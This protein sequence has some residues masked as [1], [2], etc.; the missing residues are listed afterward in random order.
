MAHHVCP[1]CQRVNPRDAVYCWFDGNVLQ[2]HAA[3]AAPVPGQLPQEF[4]FPSKRRCRTIDDFVQGCQYEWE[5]ARDLLRG[6]DFASYF[7]T[8]GRLDLARTARENEKHADP[9]I[10]LHNFLHAL[11]ITQLQGPRLDLNPRRLMLNKL[12]PGDCKQFKLTVHNQGKGLLQG[13]V[14]VAEGGQWLRVGSCNEDLAGECALKTSREQEV[15]LHVDTRGLAAPAT[16]SARLTVI[17][18]GGIAEVPVRLDL[19]TSPFAAGPFK[20]AASPREIA[21]RMRTNPRAA[22]PLLESGEVQR[23]FAANGWN[24]PVRGVP[25]Q[26]VA[27]VQQFFEAMG[28]SKPPPVHLAEAEIHCLCVAPEVATRQVVLRTPAKKWIYA[29][30][31]SDVPWLHIVTPNVAGAQQAVITFEI[32]SSLMD[33]GRSH[34]GRIQVVANAGQTLIVRVRVEVR[35]PQRPFTRRLFGGFMIVAF[36]ALA[37]R[38]LLAVPGDLLARVLLPRDHK[39][40]PGS[41]KRWET[42]A[43][44]EAGYLRRFVFFTWWLGPVLG[45]VV[46]W[47]RQGKVADALSGA[48]AGTLAGVAAAATAACVMT[49]G[50]SVPRTL[51]ADIGGRA[52]EETLPGLW[53]PLWLALVAG[54]WTALG[55]GAGLLL[56]LTGQSGR[57]LLAQIARPL[58]GLLEMI[59]MKR[60]AAVFAFR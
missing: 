45:A 36:L 46:L 60:A 50:D 5:E 1:R 26:G 37:Y 41:L 7:T 58:T 20:G 43:I 24:Y 30:A 59:G 23:W 55:A 12:R 14:S 47:R 38:M 21:E 3:G 6:G 48:I 15:L 19:G 53:T 49:L 40:P 29:Q 32:D 9:D 17:T 33:E 10:G 25:A 56:S 42:P 52:N 44:E 8:V 16:Y 31:D 13:K 28:L 11:P 35:R 57:R 54:W 51:L 2:H 34:E 27:A 4:V 39:P 18:N 22:V